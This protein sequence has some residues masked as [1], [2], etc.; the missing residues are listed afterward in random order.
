MSL[1]QSGTP[2]YVARRVTELRRELESSPWY[3]SLRRMLVYLDRDS[4]ISLRCLALGSPTENQG[5]RFQLALLLI[6]VDILEINEVSAWDPLF[7]AKDFDL[8]QTIFGI[9]VV[10]RYGA[11]TGTL[12]YLP[13]A[14]L[15]LIA[16]L[17]PNFE[18]YIGNNLASFQPRPL[19]SQEV[20]DAIEDMKNKGT[21]KTLPVIPGS[22]WVSAF[23]DLALWTRNDND[24]SD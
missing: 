24:A 10:E 23:S 19:P 7:T 12:W 15:S 4:I 5:P 9:T 6:L 3:T 2:K 21:F 8:L 14:P 18:F 16:E 1:A 17:Q 11:S 13:H 20:L 22:R